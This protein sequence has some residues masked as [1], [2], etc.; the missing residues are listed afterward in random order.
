MREQRGG[1]N[2][3]QLGTNLR[4]TLSSQLGIGMHEN[5]Q[6]FR[7]DINLPIAS[8]DCNNV[9]KSLCLCKSMFLSPSSCPWA[10]A[11]VKPRDKI[12]HEPNLHSRLGGE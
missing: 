7:T 11:I 9:Q 6:S 1:E 12:Y 3:A 4:I 5:L 2:G 8:S 10:S